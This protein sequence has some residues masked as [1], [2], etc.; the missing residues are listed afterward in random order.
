MLSDWDLSWDETNPYLTL[1]SGRQHVINH[2][3]LTNTACHYGGRRWWFICPSCKRRC[4]SLY[5][6]R[7]SQI[8]RCRLCCNLTYT[9][10][11]EA[12]KSDRGKPLFGIDL[13]VWDRDIRNERLADKWIKKE[14]LTKSERRKVAAYLGVP[15]FMVRNYFYKPETRA[16]MKAA[17]YTK[18]H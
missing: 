1:K 7:D 4:A 12:H 2:I 8:Y 3:R 18:T 6:P 15:L 5:M 9:S 13:S 11:Q 16:K 17:Q 10:A 14:H